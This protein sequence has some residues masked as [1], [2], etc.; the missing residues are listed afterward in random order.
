MILELVHVNKHSYQMANATSLF[1]QI[2]TL[3]VFHAFRYIAQTIEALLLITYFFYCY[4]LNKRLKM[5]C[6]LTSTNTQG[7]NKHSNSDVVSEL[8]DIQAH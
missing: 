6:N 2:M 3:A 5:V 8:N 7:K 4:K 1:T